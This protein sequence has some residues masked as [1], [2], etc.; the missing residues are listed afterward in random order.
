MASITETKDGKLE[1]T[2]QVYNSTTTAMEFSTDDEST[3]QRC[4]AHKD[5]QLHVDLN[6]E[7][8]IS[9]TKRQAKLLHVPTCS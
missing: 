4:S 8:I 3:G 7:K 2:E 1:V 9:K 5:R 6:L